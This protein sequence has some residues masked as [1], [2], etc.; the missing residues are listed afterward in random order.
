M[1]SDDL[2]ISDTATTLGPA[3]GPEPVSELPWGQHD[4]VLRDGVKRWMLQDPLGAGGSGTVWRALDLMR[5]SLAVALK[6][7]PLADDRQRA[8]FVN[9]AGKTAR[10]SDP[11]LVRVHDVAVV[12]GWG[13]LVQELVEGGT[14]SDRLRVLRSQG[15]PMPIEELERLLRSAL[16]GLSVLHEAGFVHRDIKPS[17]LALRDGGI[18]LLDLGLAC[19]SGGHGR[20]LDW[21]N[22]GTRGY[23]PPEQERDALGVL[24][25]ADLYALGVTMMAAATLSRPSEW[26]RPY[27]ATVDLSRLPEPLRS[28]LRRAVAE[29]PTA[30]WQDVRSWLNVLDAPAAPVQPPAI[31]PAPAEATPAEARRPLKPNRVPVPQERAPVPVVREPK[32]PTAPSEARPK[33]PRV[34]R[35]SSLPGAELAEGV[36][37]PRKRAQIAAILGVL[38]V[39]A[40]AAASLPALRRTVEPDAWLSQR[41]YAM[42]PIR[43]GSFLMGSPASE[44]GHE[45]DETQHAVTVAGFAIGATEVTQKLFREVMGSNPAATATRLWLGKDDGG[46]CATWGVG[47]DLPVHCVT[48][49]EAAEFCNR[50]SN[51]VGLEPQ[52]QLAGEEPIRF[53]ADSKPGYRLPTEAEWEYAARAG[54]DGRYAGTGDD[55]S[56]C[57]YANVGNPATREK[58]PWMKWGMFDCDDGFTG[59]AP[60]RRFMPNAWGLFDMTGNVWEWTDDS[61]S[62]DYELLPSDNPASLMPRFVEAG[63]AQPEIDPSRATVRG[64]SWQR[65]DIVRVANRYFG[66]RGDRSWYVGFRVV[67]GK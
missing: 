24:A 22:P 13:L 54:T 38:L 1:A 41:G 34:P 56:L 59:L 20:E 60:V 15:Q 28:T 14:L 26:S 63:A 37:R 8:T 5:G 61:Y 62:P 32:R 57:G 50:L 2:P 7:I 18:V 67:R 39:G 52:Y 44:S 19:S 9:E 48:W 21:G 12:D 31:R 66:G 23:M 47:D 10:L 33:P 65:A 11:A 3:S 45:E 49:L 51:L 27:A 35:S 29:A 58:H 6:F 42:V 30:R 43:G 4:F 36:S 46:A 17:N 64:G 40:V 16:A 25:N 53:A 55:E